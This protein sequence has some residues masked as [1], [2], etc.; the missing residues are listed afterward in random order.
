MFTPES[1]YE[2]LSDE[3]EMQL[4]CESWGLADSELFASFQLLRPYS[5]TKNAALK[6]ATTREDMVRH[7]A[8]MQVKNI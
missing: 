1:S 4:V 2:V 5:K 8:K 7:A 6:N 3:R